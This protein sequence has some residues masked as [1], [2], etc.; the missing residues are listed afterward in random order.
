MSAEPGAACGGPPSGQAQPGACLTVPLLEIGGTHVTAAL[1][2]VGGAGPAQV[3]A[4][5]RAPLDAHGTAEAVV[6]ALLRA[7]REL[8]PVD[9]ARWAVALPGP[10]DYARGIARYHGV[11]KFEALDGLDLGAALRAGLPSCTDVAFLNDAW[12]FAYGERAEGAARGHDRVVGITL[13]T[14]VGSAFL[15][16]GAAVTEGPGVPPQ[17]RVDLLVHDGR[18]L[19]DTV[20]RRALTAAYAGA[21]GRRSDVR[22]IAA[23]A[24]GGEVA[25]LRV[26]TDAFG[27]LGRVLAVWVRRFEAGALVVGGSMTGSWDLIGPALTAGLLAGGAESPRPVRAEHVQ[28]AALVGAAWYV[29][30]PRADADRGAGPRADADRGAGPRAD[31]CR[32]VRGSEDHER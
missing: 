19:E 22:E 5:R 4:T 14:G 21:T 10:F 7:G 12:A 16:D 31:T 28:E 6:A 3:V 25:A 1:V 20:S 23:A 13:G 26:L 27:A 30:G 11:G 9:P 18:P 24:R 2:R 15:A 32:S 17:G 8:G 29:A